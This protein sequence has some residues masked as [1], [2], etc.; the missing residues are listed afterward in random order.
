MIIQHLANSKK[1][2]IKDLKI[3]NAETRRPNRESIA[4]YKESLEVRSGKLKQS[5]MESSDDETKQ[6]DEDDEEEEFDVLDEDNDEDDKD[7]EG[8]EEGA[9]PL[10]NMIDADG[11]EDEVA[12]SEQKVN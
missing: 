1:R 6:S 8:D 3:E 10:D 5:N 4:A 9:E 7:T 11:D 2:W 12:A